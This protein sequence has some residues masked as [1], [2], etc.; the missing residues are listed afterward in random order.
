MQ[1]GRSRLKILGPSSQLRVKIFQALIFA[2]KLWI[3]PIRDVEDGI[4]HLRELRRGWSDFR[5]DLSMA[6]LGV[7]SCSERC[8]IFKLLFVLFNTRSQAFHTPAMRRRVDI[9]NDIS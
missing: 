3:L 5:Y 7:P 6:R 8:F 2:E 9:S 4:I 1:N